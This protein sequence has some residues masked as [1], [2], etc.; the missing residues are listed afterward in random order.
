MHL[1]TIIGVPKSTVPVRST[2]EGRR[3]VWSASSVTSK[4]LSPPEFW[5]KTETLS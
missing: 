4:L 2:L 5:M 1:V 3:T